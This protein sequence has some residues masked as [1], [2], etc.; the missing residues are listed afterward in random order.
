VIA[1]PNGVSWSDYLAG[2]SCSNT[3]SKVGPDPSVPSTH[4]HTSVSQTAS[5]SLRSVPSIDA[6]A[7]HN[8][9]LFEPVTVANP[10]RLAV[11]MR[12]GASEAPG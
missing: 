4:T 9:C 6:R 1:L 10:T 8:L 11:A 7:G 12:G 5:F 3:G 2:K